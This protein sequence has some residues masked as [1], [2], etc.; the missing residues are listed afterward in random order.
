MKR[1]RLMEVC[2]TTTTDTPSPLPHKRPRESERRS[3]KTEQLEEDRDFATKL[4]SIT[5]ISGDLAKLDAIYGGAYDDA[6]LEQFS[7]AVS[8]CLCRLGRHTVGQKSEVIAFIDAV[9]GPVDLHQMVFP[10]RRI[11]VFQLGYFEF[12]QITDQKPDLVDYG[13][14]MADMDIQSLPLPSD[15][16]ICEKA[17]LLKSIFA[18]D[19]SGQQIERDHFSK[20]ERLE[21]PSRGIDQDAADDDD[22]DD[23]QILDLE[24][25]SSTVKT[26]ASDARDFGDDAEEGEL[27]EDDADEV[28][29]EMD[30][31]PLDNLVHSIESLRR[32]R[33]MLCK[34]RPRNASICE[35]LVG[36]LVVCHSKSG[37]G[38]VTA[39]TEP[40]KRSRENGADRKRSRENGAGEN[41]AAKTEPVENGAA[42][43]FQ[44]E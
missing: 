10:Q 28:E 2:D 12:D 15:E 16:F 30:E 6:Q 40:R 21:E 11:F 22:A 32:V 25:A 18:F 29:E 7:R 27:L 23:V 9:V 36:C 8:G 14:W 41:G 39:K 19:A 37:T 5:L 26:E 44:I 1:E 43:R 35:C 38:K 42:Y 31:P 24:T 13:P 17:Q 3:F 34:V 20:S 33:L 4:A